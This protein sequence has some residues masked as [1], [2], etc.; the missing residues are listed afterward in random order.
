MKWLGFG[1]V[2]ERFGIDVLWGA[3]EISLCSP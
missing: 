1:E 2:V 3:V